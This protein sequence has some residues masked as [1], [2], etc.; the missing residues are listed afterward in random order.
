MFFFRHA[1]LVLGWWIYSL[2]VRQIFVRNAETLLNLSFP[3]A[4]RHFPPEWLP[5]MKFKAQA[6]QGAKIM[7]DFIEKPY[8][9]AKRQMV[10]RIIPSYLQAVIVS[11]LGVEQRYTFFHYPFH[12]E[13]ES[14]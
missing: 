9:F 12:P 7:S 1:S 8:A 14:E 11:S 4:V 6:R 5:G 3:I 10:R 13:R 2:F